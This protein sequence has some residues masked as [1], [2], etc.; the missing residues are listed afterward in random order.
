MNERRLAV[1]E[2]RG[3]SDKLG[4][5]VYQFK[6]WLKTQNRQIK[7]IPGESFGIAYNDPDEASKEDFRFDLGVTVPQ[8]LVLKGEVVE[9]ILPSGRYVVAMHKG[10]RDR[11]SD[12]VYNLYWEWLPQSGE[13]LGDLPCIFCYYNFDDE[14]A[15]TEL[16]T[17]CWLLLK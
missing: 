8:Q 5:S 16:L 4:G 7:L 17:E 12:T 11:I 1:M 3:D 10:S 9:K 2:H 13:E 6:R 15:E 14:V